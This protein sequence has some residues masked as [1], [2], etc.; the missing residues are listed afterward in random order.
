MKRNY[1]IKIKIH[2]SKRGTYLEDKTI[3]DKILCKEL[4]ADIIF[5]DEYV[6]AFK[7]INPQAP[8]HVLV[9]PKLKCKGF[10]QLQDIEVMYCGEYLKRISLVADKLGLS[11]DGYRIVFN[12]GPNGQQTVNYIHAHILGGKQLNWPPG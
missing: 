1:S 9:I 11:N 2:R 8:I 4:P 7:D 12:H 3:F 5:E 6:L 10:A